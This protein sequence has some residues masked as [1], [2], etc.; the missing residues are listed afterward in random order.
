M[1]ETRSTL[2]GGIP[3]PPK[4]MKVTWDHYS[5]LYGRKTHV[6]NHQPALSGAFLKWGYPISK[7]NKS[8]IYL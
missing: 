8:S 6:P 3:T 2:V 5:Q 7:S 1:I 4:N